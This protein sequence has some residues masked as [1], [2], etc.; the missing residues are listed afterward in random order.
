MTYHTNTSRI[1]K[2][3]LDLINRAPAHYFERYLNPKA[4]PQK[5]TP[6]LIIG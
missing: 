1:S 2:S 3:G 6:A 4:P 5:E